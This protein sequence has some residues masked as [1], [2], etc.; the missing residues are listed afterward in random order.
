MLR[1]ELLKKEA[2]NVA[3]AEINGINSTVEIGTKLLKIKDLKL[4]MLTSRN[5]IS[6]YIELKYVVK[7]IKAKLID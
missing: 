3:M 4:L 2:N 6:E 7:G 1:I 5:F